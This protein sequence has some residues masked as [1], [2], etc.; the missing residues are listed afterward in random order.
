MGGRGGLIAGGLAGAGLFV[1]AVVAVGSLLGGDEDPT[2]EPPTTPEEPPEPPEPEALESFRLGAPEDCG[3]NPF[4]LDGLARTYGID[5]TD[6]LVPLEPGEPIVAALRD[7]T[8]EVGVLFT[9]DPLLAEDDLVV[10]EDDR[11]ML[12]AENVV[13]VARAELIEQRGEGL[14]VALDRVSEQLTAEVVADLVSEL[15]A[16]TPPDDA[17]AEQVAGLDLDSVEVADGEPVRIGASIFD[18]DRAIA[19]VYAAG[20]RAQGV[21]AEV[22]ELNGFR[23]LEM[24]AILDR[25]IDIAIDYAGSLLEFLDGFSSLASPDG[26]E[27]VSTLRELIEVAGY[28][29]FE[30]AP[31]TSAN[32]FVVTAATAQRYGLA[33]L[34]DLVDAAPA[35]EPAPPPGERPTVDEPLLLLGDTELLV[36][37]TGPEVRQLQELLAEAGYEPGPI[38]GIFEEPTR[39][40]VAA[41]QADAGLPLDGVAGPQTI[42]A[43]E[44]AIAAAEE[45]ATGEDGA[46]PAPPEQPE[47]PD[48]TPDRPAPDGAVVHLTFDDGPNS[49]Y[50]PQILDLLSRYDAQAV[51]F[52]IGQQIGGSRAIVDRMVAEGHRLG[53]HS[54]SHPSLAGLSRP[55]F[56]QEIGRTQEAIAA[57]TGSGA[58]CLRPPYGAMDSQTRAWAAEAG[59]EVVLWDIDPQDWARPGVASIVGSVVNYARPGDVVLFHDGG[60]NREQTVAALEQILAQLSDRGF[61]FTIAPGC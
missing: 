35:A 53:N 32:A 42:A 34:S 58:S 40:A 56:D 50:T 2:P 51:F 20:L 44:E 17:A 49:S 10:L 52:A 12:G 38:N 19:Y 30:P 46:D 13:P 37:D 5:V 23:A 28:E 59:M 18:E 16:G 7:G 54:W 25:E 45:A 55:A 21:E 31:A 48:P 29:V 4:C 22:V 24:A 9:S 39:R 6:L 26:E 8:V 14:R 47:P 11:Q 1:L 43:L 36:G 33:S 41:F 57:V 15:R 60:G 27:T 3:T 61:S